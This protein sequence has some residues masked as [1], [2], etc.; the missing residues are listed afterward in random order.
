MRDTASGD[1]WS[2]RSWSDSFWPPAPMPGSSRKVSAPKR[3]IT[4]PKQGRGASS[5]APYEAQESTAPSVEKARGPALRTTGEPVASRTSE[6]TRDPA[7]KPAPKKTPKGPEES[8]DV[9]VLG[10]DRR[11][12]DE[13]VR[14][15]TR[16]R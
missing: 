5:V 16:T 6:P 14:G 7:D 4:R 3:V 1:S 12:S 10:V 15:P 11:P 13:E 2:L 9:L 8:L